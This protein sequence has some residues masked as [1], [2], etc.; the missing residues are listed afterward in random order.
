MD[1]NLKNRSGS[2]SNEEH[3]SKGRG[4]AK[5]TSQPGA[6]QKSNRQTGGNNRHEK[7]DS[8]GAGRNT[9]KK[10]ENAI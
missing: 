1:K 7:D 2:Q 9:T 5:K 6:P 8:D 10:G 3:D 4:D